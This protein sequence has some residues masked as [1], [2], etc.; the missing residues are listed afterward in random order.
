MV[1]GNLTRLELSQHLK[2]GVIGCT[3]VGKSSFFNAFAGV[4]NKLKLS[5]VDN[6]LFTTVDNNC[7]TIEISDPRIDQITA[8]FPSLVGKK[9]YLT[10][11]DTPGLIKNSRNGAGVGIAGLEAL[12]SVDII[13]HIVRGFDDNELTVTY[14][15]TVDAK[16]DLGIVEQELMLEDLLIIDNTINIFILEIEN[17]NGGKELRYE[18]DL[19]LKAYEILV[20]VPRPPLKRKK[21][22]IVRPPFPTVCEGKPLRF[23]NFDTT[24]VVYL[25]K[26]NFFTAKE[27]LYLVNLTPRDFMR[28]SN[29]PAYISQ[30]SDIIGPGSYFLPMSAVFEISLFEEELAGTLGEYLEAN[31]THVSVIPTIIEECYRRLNLI[32]FYTVD[33]GEVQS[34]L[35]FRGTQLIF[36]GTVISDLH[37]KN[38]ISGDVCTAGEYC[39][40]KGDW[41]KLLKEGIAQNRSGKYS[42]N[43]GELIRFRLRDP[44]TGKL[45][46]LED[47]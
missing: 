28:K 9:K 26:Y 39:S 20:G 24:E 47:L 10:L 35:T 25:K 34:W 30:M 46:K 40:G 19:L 31:P 16:R 7:V 15:G 17:K 1:R 13:L 2:V 27:M 12:R 23:G 5:A 37:E 6:S 14:E 42:I 38:F 3:N 29:V 43:D 4:K 21:G 44:I 33:N 32:Q 45:K 8:T 18:Y 41:V 22:V 36:A 11:I